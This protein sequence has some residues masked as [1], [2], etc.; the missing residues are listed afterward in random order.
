MLGEYELVCTEYG[1]KGH[2]LVVETMSVGWKVGDRVRTDP[3][4]PNSLRCPL[5]KR[6]FMKV[7]KVPTYRRE[8]P[9]KGFSKLPK[10]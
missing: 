4:D 10:E 3:A 1:C 5:C 8:V 9:I 7:S 2:R 6:G